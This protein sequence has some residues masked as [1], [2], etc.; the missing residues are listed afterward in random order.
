MLSLL[1]YRTYSISPVKGYIS[2]RNS[3]KNDYLESVRY[4]ASEWEVYSVQQDAFMNVSAFF[5]SLCQY[6]TQIEETFN[7]NYYDNEERRQVMSLVSADDEK[8]D[9]NLHIAL[10]LANNMVNFMSHVLYDL[11]KNDGWKSANNLRGLFAFKTERRNLTTVI[12]RERSDKDYIKSLL[13]C[14]KCEVTYKHLFRTQSACVESGNTKKETIKVSFVLDSDKKIKETGSLKIEVH[15]IGSFFYS[16]L[17]KIMHQAMPNYLLPNSRRSSDYADYN[18]LLSIICMEILLVVSEKLKKAFLFQENGNEFF[19]SKVFR[20]IM[21]K[22]KFDDEDTKTFQE[23]LAV[24]VIAF[25][26][27]FTFQK[28][29]TNAYTNLIMQ[30]IDLLDRNWYDYQPAINL[31]YLSIY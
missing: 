22:T 9:K 12:D 24:C 6:L 17:S 28:K 3:K 7:I 15:S 5:N 14:M 21:N 18:I 27:F 8:T 25:N 4:W 10:S 16:F 1:N 2:H 26:N 31:K 30:Y 13:E 23:R 20:G 11:Q 19:D 29:I